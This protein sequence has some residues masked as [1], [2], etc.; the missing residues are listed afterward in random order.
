MALNKISKFLKYLDRTSQGLGQDWTGTWTKL[1]IYLNKNGQIPG[2]DL[3][4]V[5]EILGQN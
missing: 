1:D 3:T 2:Q 4:G 5:P